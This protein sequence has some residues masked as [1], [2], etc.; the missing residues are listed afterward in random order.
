MKAL[1][2]DRQRSRAETGNNQNP[3]KLSGKQNQNTPKQGLI[4]YQRKNKN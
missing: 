3:A 1:A 2:G 4:A